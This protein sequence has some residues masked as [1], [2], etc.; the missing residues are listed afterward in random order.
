MKP[1]LWILV[2]IAILG[3]IAILVIV[4]RG[5]WTR[6]AEASYHDALDR[7]LQLSSP[8]FENKGRIPAEF[9]CEGPGGSPPLTWANVPE[10]T[11]SYVLIVTDVDIPSPRLQ[12]T[13]FVHWVLYDLPGGTRALDARITLNELARLEAVMGRNGYGQR[14]YVSPCPVSGTHHYVYRLYALD[15][16]DL[17]PRQ[18][19]K[20]G[21]LKAMEGH[22]LAYGELIGAYQCTTIK[23]LSALRRAMSSQS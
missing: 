16:E 10:G 5:L 7:S 17:Q 21:M 19:S 13:E 8:A 18:D 12:L 22:V 9:S 2:G 20:G 6:R 14:E 4:L 1:V 11:R 3:G 23:G 15:V